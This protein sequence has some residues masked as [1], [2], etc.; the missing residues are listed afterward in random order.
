MI[1]GGRIIED[2][3]IVVIGNRISAVGPTAEVQI[4]PDAERI[5][6]GGATVMPGLIDV[7]AH[8]AQG[9]RGITPQRN[10]INWASVAFGTTTIHDPSNSTQEVFAASE[11]ARQGRI[12]APRIFSTGTI[13]YGA[14]GAAHAE[15]QSI[16]DA[17]FHLERMKAVGAFSVKSYNQPRRDQRQMV[18]EAARRLGMMVVPEGGAL[19]QHNMTMVVDGHTSVEHTLPVERIYDDVCQLWRASSTGYTPTL[20]VA[21]GG[22]GGE[23]YWYARTNVWENEHLLRFVPRFVVDPRSRRRMDAPDGDW[24]HVRSAGIAARLLEAGAMSGGVRD[25]AGGGPTIGAHGQL[26]GLAAHWEMWMLV[27]GGFTPFEALRAATRDGAWYLGFDGD[28][29]SLA[30]GKLADLIVLERDPLADIR[31][32]TTLRHVMLNGRLFDAQTM[33]ELLPRQGAP[34]KFFFEDLHSGLAV[35]RSLQAL[36]ELARGCV[37]CGRAGCCPEEGE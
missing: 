3:S 35:T 31:N 33:Q 32:T 4:P 17:L 24:N 6:L 22:L 10:W 29:G 1:R 13:L 28:L 16:E 27:Q 36:H 30:P 7:H 14:A 25:G 18:V 5:D 34:P 2:G 21:Y 26:A 19:H 12:I 9:E 11:L 37:G 8:G 20:G 15:V 23:N